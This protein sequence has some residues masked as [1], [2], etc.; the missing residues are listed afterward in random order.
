MGETTINSLTNLKKEGESITDSSND[1][2]KTIKNIYEVYDELNE[3]WSGEKATE[4]KNKIEKFREPLNVI[5][6]AIGSHGDAVA[7]A[8]QEFERF[9]RS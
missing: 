4:Y 7:E 3:K 5:S 1:F 6:E 8:A 2:I 9:E